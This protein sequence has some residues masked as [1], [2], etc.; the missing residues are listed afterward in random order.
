MSVIGEKL[1]EINGRITSVTITEVGNAVNVEAEVG[2]VGTVVATVTFGVPVDAAGE[3]GPITIRGQ[4]FAVD[5]SSRSFT[6]G[7]TWHTSGN[8]S[9]EIKHISLDSQGQRM[10]VVD[11]FDLATRTNKGTIYALD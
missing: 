3:T 9:W 6:S 1:G 10:F 5:G 11:E 4:I 7:G 2:S 8:H